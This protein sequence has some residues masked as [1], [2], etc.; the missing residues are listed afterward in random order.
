MPFFL[1]RK[2]TD[3]LFVDFFSVFGNEVI[4][5]IPNDDRD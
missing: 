2:L 4:Y 5:T 1:R 3:F